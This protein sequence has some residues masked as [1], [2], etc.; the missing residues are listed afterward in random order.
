MN[1]IEKRDL[2]EQERKIF[3]AGAQRVDKRTGSV[4]FL[5]WPFVTAIAGLIAGEEFLAAT[6]KSASAEEGDAKAAQAGAAL[7]AA[8]DD[9]QASEPK[10]G[11]EDETAKGPAA[12]SDA[13]AAQ[14]DPTGLV[15]QPVAHASAGGGGGGRGGGGGDDADSRDHDAHTSIDDSSVNPL[16]ADSHFGSSPFPGGSTLESVQPIVG[17][18]IIGST[19]PLGAVATPTKDGAGSIAVEGGQPALTTVTD[20]VGTLPSAAPDTSAGQAPGPADTL[21]ALATATDGPIEVP[22]SPTAAL[23][24]VATERS[25]A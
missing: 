1:D 3:E 13:H 2:F 20:T 16:S 14:F 25:T 6:F 23:A 4:S 7:Q 8:N 19:P 21:L 17:P 5:T 9:P 15:A 22:G 11:A 12:S 18:A 10:S 24:Q